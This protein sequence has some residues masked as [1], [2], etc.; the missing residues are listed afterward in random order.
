MN[1]S[2]IG[3]KQTCGKTYELI[4]KSSEEW[5]Y[6]I[7]ANEHQAENISF[8]AKSMNLN[9][10]YPITVDELPISTNSS[11]KEVLVDEIEQVLEMFIQ[12]PIIKASTSMNMKEMDSLCEKKTVEDMTN[13][14]LKVAKELRRLM[15][16]SDEFI[17]KKKTVGLS[18]I[19]EQ[20]SYH[21]HGKMSGI[22]FALGDE[23]VFSI[24]KSF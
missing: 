11:I 1:K 14:Q 13:Q 5:I 7:C 21:V 9:I 3:G 18:K 6:I 8:Q 22:L 16:K 19:E 17:E 24:L 12:K 23:K 2:L 20:A 4:K 15:K 10:P